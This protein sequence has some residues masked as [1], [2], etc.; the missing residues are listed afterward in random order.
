MANHIRVPHF[1]KS[2]CNS[3]P[4][5]HNKYKCRKGDY[6]SF[7]FNY[8]ICESTLCK[9]HPLPYQL[10]TNVFILIFDQSHR[11]WATIIKEAYCP[12]SKSTQFVNVTIQLILRWRWVWLV[13][14]HPIISAVNSFNPI[15]S[16][17]RS[18]PLFWFLLSLIYWMI[19]YTNWIIKSSFRCLRLEH[20]E[21]WLKVWFALAENYSCLIIL[22]WILFVEYVRTCSPWTKIE[23]P[24]NFFYMVKV[25]ALKKN[26]VELESAM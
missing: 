1:T 7:H 10:V 8:F 21:E 4:D 3:H 15:Q 17:P 19:S 11:Q 13:D 12:S 26:V 22:D 6:L 2:S 24:S 20:H 16:Q 18:Y 14:S 23:T 5:V 9:S 25:E